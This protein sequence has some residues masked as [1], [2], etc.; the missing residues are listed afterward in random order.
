[1]EEVTNI[2]GTRE[3]KSLGCEHNKMKLSI[4]AEDMFRYRSLSCKIPD[5]EEIAYTLDFVP[6]LK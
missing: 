5:I 4:T 2:E 1:M 6:K 3:L